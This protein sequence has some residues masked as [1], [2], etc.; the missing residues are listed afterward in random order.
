MNRRRRSCS[1]S[2]VVSDHRAAHRRCFLAG[3]GFVWLPPPYRADQ[4]DFSVGYDVYDRFDL[5]RPGRP[6]LY[7]TEE[8]LKSLAAM[9][10]RAGLSLHVDFVINHNGF[11]NLG[12]PGFKAAGGYP[13]FVLTLPKRRRR[14]FPFGVRGRRRARTAGGADRHR[15]REEPPVHSQSRRDRRYA[16]IPA[17]TDAGV[18]APG[19]RAGSANR[20]FYPDI[21]HKTIFVFDPKT[22]EREH[23]R[24]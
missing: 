6:T 4:G 7:G 24:A 5:G 22:N 14:R 1:G 9:L 11:S 3:Y 19:E 8:G 18:R 21:G 10:H 2:I 12:T 13:G 17:G 15:S 20:R 23:R 16:N